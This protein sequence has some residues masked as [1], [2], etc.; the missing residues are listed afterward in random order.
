MTTGWTKISLYLIDS[1]EDIVLLSNLKEKL[2]YNINHLSKVYE[3]TS[4]TIITHAVN[5]M[6]H[7]IPVEPL[8]VKEQETE[9]LRYLD[10]LG[11]Q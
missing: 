4:L 3:Q 1:A 6:R 8:V 5:T 11:V 7:K 2:Q 9:K 10:T